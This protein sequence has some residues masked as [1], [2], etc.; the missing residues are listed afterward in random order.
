MTD[1]TSNLFS[2]RSAR[3]TP[4]FQEPPRPHPIGARLLNFLNI[5][6]SAP[7]KDVFDQLKASF[8]R[9]QEASRRL[10]LT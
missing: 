5:V 7:V 4:P 8:K 6:H 1:P 10:S 3:T 2:K 9:R